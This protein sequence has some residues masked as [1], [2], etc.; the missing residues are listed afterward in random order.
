MTTVSV[1]DVALRGPILCASGTA[2]HGA[3]LAAF[4]DLALLGGVVVKSLAAYP[5]AG[6]PPPRLHA[7]PLGMINSVGLEGPGVAGWVE[8]DL[9]ALESTGATVVASM[10][11]RSVA[12]YAEAA[13][14]LA[15]L[16]DR[17]AAVEINLSCP[18]VGHGDGRAVMF[19]HDP[20]L[21]GE[22][23]RATG[24]LTVARWAKLS[25][26]TDRLL[27]VAA[28][29]VASGA[30][31]LTLVNT[32]LGMRIDITTGR[33]VLGGGGGGV[34]GM[35]IHPVA[36]R[37]VHDVHRAM[38][39]VPIVG[40]GG[41][42]SGADAIEM[43]MAGASAVQVGTAT[44]ADPRAPWHVQEQMQ[45]WAEREGVRDWSE[46]VGVATRDGRPR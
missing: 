5:W 34:S 10:W 16:G 28:A 31:A 6:N 23:M 7:L 14:A 30:S 15:P 43:M 45:R 3:E 46:I 32:L 8:H 26:N 9:P 40:V 19:A 27:E 38:P 17:I 24:M 39:D 4:G 33:A 44:F 36:V 11:G 2:G 41:V 18:N 20:T 21:V 25:P 22:V 42:V 1:G 37:C 13:E 12:D 29:A 35:G